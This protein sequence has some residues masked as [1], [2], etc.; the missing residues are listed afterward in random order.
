MAQPIDPLPAL[1]AITSRTP[2]RHSAKVSADRSYRYLW[3]L[4]MSLVVGLLI[5]TVDPTALP[6]LS[7]LTLLV[8]DDNVD[9]LGVLGMFLRACGAQVL[10]APGGL[11][12]LSY[13][14]TQTRIDAVISDLSMPAMDG[15]EFV[16]R[17][18]AH[19]KGRSTPAIAVS[20]FHEQYM[21]T[22]GAGFDAFFPKPVNL[23]GLGTAIRNL[24][25]SR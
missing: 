25:R 1:D 19:P 22:T 24:V 13:V 10:A 20:A 8:V 11:R 3:G 4:T 23:D 15:V 17:L 7:G 21:N 12:A 6:D 5:S 2:Q 16:Q 14:D 18:R 9:S